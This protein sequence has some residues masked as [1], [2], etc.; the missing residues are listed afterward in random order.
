MK[1]YLAIDI[2]GTNIKYGI[3]LNEELIEKKEIATPLANIDDLLNQI[4]RIKNS[5]SYE[6]EGVAISAPGLIN[7]KIG[8]MY[9]GGGLRY[10]SQ[11]PMGDK[12][13]ELLSLPVTIENDGKCA[14]LAE[15]WKGTLKGVDHGL[16]LLIGTGIGGG[17]VIN[18]QLHRG[19]NFAAGELSALLTSLTDSPSY[20][21]MINGVNSLLQPY[22]LKKNLSPSSVNGRDFF[23]DIHKNDEDTWEIFTSFCKSF[24]KGI[25]SV[26]TVLDVET[27]AIGGG[28][29]AQE[30][31]ITT[32][33]NELEKFMENLKMLPIKKPKI[34][35]CEFSNDS[36]LIG[37]LY[38]HLTLNV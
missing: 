5:F 35:R 28:I 37:A 11:Y 34:V 13:S 4:V 9:T 21:A 25:F 22:A 15:V 2:G 19:T 12:L 29:S 33:D 3:F 36:N 16:V 14:A 1:Y 24:A 20:W 31:V 26:Q 23:K 6:F 10:I 32:I 30:I 18:G 27:V 38:H 7:S 17:V 8:F